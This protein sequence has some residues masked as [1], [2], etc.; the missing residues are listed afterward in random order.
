MR[1]TG[2]FRLPKHEKFKYNPIY[3]NEEKV[4]QEQRIKR[5]KKELELEGEEGEKKAVS[6]SNIKGQFHRGSR[7]NS[8]EKRKSNLRVFVILIILIVLFYLLLA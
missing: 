3:Y 2:F 8:S 6:I 5:I 4:A 7:L 1:L